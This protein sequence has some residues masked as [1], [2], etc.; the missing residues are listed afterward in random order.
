M[1]FQVAAPIA[2]T[3]KRDPSAASRPP[4]AS[5]PGPDT[6]HQRLLDQ[7]EILDQL[8]DGEGIPMSEWEG[9]FEKC[10]ICKKFMLEAVYKAHSRD[11]WGV[12]DEES[13]VDEWGKE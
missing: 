5:N 10:Y 6:P 2:S 12:S 13:E 11:C 9:L 8:A 7:R 4:T 3:S 1:S